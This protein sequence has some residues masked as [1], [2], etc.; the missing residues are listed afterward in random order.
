M[1]LHVDQIYAI[2]GSDR[3]PDKDDL[4]DF[5]GCMQ[6][7]GVNGKLGLG[8][9]KKSEVQLFLTSTLWYGETNV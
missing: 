2:N 1:A 9:K 5:S 6:S 3:G 7:C 4:L 8:E